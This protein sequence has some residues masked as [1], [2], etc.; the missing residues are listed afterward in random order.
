MVNHGVVGRA[1]CRHQYR[2][3]NERDVV[4]EMKWMLKLK[5]LDIQWK[6]ALVSA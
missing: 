1:I 2:T 6:R 4:P 3:T 5:A